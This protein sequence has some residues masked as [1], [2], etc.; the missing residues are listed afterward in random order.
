MF[1]FVSL[2]KIF[3]SY[4]TGVVLWL[5][6]CLTG[7]WLVSF[8][9]HS[10]RSC[11]AFVL[12]NRLESAGTPYLSKQ[13]PNSFSD[14]IFTRSF[15]LI[16]YERR[17]SV[18]ITDIQNFSNLGCQE[19]SKKWNSQT[20]DWISNVIQMLLMIWYVWRLIWKLKQSTFC[21]IFVF[22]IC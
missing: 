22:S 17:L 5:H 13:K 14:F 4:L 21:L 8:V 1:S 15:I 16:M 6:L 9:S 20:Q 2:S 12:K 18:F 7:V 19:S 10:C 3:H 11:L